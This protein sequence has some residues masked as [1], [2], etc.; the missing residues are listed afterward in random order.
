MTYRC[1][2]MTGQALCLGLIGS[3]LSVFAQDAPK[4]SV[5]VEKNEV[6]V[7]EPFIYQIQVENAT[8]ASA[9]DLAAATDDFTVEYA[10]PKRQSSQSISLVNGRSTRTVVVQYLMNYRLTAKRKGTLQIPSVEVRVGGQ[11]FTTEPVAIRV[12]E[13]VPVEDY[14]LVCEFSKDTCYAGEPITM[15]TTFYIARNMRSFTLS[16]PILSSNLFYS[17]PVPMQQRANRDYFQ[18]PI[19]GEDVVAEKGDARLNGQ[20]CVTLTFKHVLVPREAGELTVPDGTVSVEAVSKTRS[21]RRSPFDDFSLFGSPDDYEQVIVPADS[22]KLSVKPVP[23]EGKPANYSGLVGAFTLST[24]AAPTDVN[25][26]DPITLTIALE[27]SYYLRHFELPPLQ[28]Q[29]ALAANFRIPEEMAPGKAEDNRKVFTQTIRAQSDKVTAIP[30]IELAYFDTNAGTYKTVSSDPIPL[31][32]RETQV[33]T[34]ADAVGYSPHVGTV[35]HVAMNEGIAHNF[36]ESD[37]LNNQYYGPDVWMRTAR[38][39]LLLLIPPALYAL[40]AG[41]VL[42]RR[43]GGIR[44]EGRYRK[45]ARSRL[46]AALAG[47]G[48]EDDVYGASLGALRDYLGAKVGLNASALTFSDAQEPLGKAGASADSL[49]VLKGIFDACEAHR[50]SGG[51]MTPAATTD[52]VGRVRQC[53]RGLDKE[54]G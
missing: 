50:Y 2:R 31:A 53:V 19:N 17:E 20:Q 22:L 16:L 5:G 46:E 8:A 37:A 41:S 44:F 27:G 47:V 6:F 3:A 11:T 15:T 9:P 34:A 38:S 42:F 12:N 1:T 39:W 14:K 30:P 36:T 43:L 4:V 33:V 13:P 48:P 28:N 54:I 45:Q 10:G 52:F 32:V 25:V 49:S 23:E 51:S 24:T 40:L 21:R 35:E 7:G 26:G 18:I 29:P